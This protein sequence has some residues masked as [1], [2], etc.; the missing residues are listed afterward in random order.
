MKT[1]PKHT[2]V[3][4]GFQVPGSDVTPW[5]SQ[6]QTEKIAQYI[7]LSK[8][9]RSESIPL[10]EWKRSLLKEGKLYIVQRENGRLKS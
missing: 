3:D 9:P 4:H 6:I 2:R 5:A 7:L 1:R 10:A 8:A